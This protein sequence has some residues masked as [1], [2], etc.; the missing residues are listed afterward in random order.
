MA[1]RVLVGGAIAHHPLGGGGNTW[2]FLQYVLG[3]RRLGC[4]VLYVEH[5]SSAECWDAEWRRVPFPAS[6]N[7]QYFR[8]VMRAFGLREAAALL[9]Y[10]GDGYVGRSRAEVREWAGEADL[11]INCSGRFHLRDILNAPRR[12]LYLD[13]DPGFTQVW[14]RGYGVDMNLAGH[15]VHVTVGQNL[16]RSGCPFP[17]LDIE[18]RTTLPPVVLS[19]WSTAEPPG[20]HYTT[21]ADWRGY[22]EVEWDGIWYGQKADE[23]LRVLTLP[24]RVACP[25][26]I[27]LAIHPA[28]ADRERLV[29]H[30]W[31]L[32]DPR[33][34]A[35]DPD[36]YRTYVCSSRGEFSVA[37]HGYA[38][39]FTGWMSDRTVC[40]LAAGRPAVVQDTGLRGRLPT[41]E[42]L[43]LFSGV[44]EAAAALQEVE[45]RYA[46]HA[47][48]AR[49]LAREVFDSDRVLAHLL[50]LAG[51]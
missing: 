23:F 5:L 20:A 49:A 28:E 45:R 41:G 31:R 13:M 27:C 10:D 47:E 8:R 43:V 2:A 9:E 3:L 12:R 19:E 17:T 34:Q 33:I 18:W 32:T 44:D 48:A 35:A 40:Y 39:G 1:S 11:F 4:E 16:G 21:V 30:G 24:S 26:E 29:S 14:Q 37:K 38:A 46:V 22:S 50:N 36:A 15:E 6:A 51:M 25:L 7:A 42:G